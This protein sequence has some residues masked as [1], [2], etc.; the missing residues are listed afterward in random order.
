MT[1]ATS[2][3]GV[4]VNL[5]MGTASTNP[6]R[7]YEIQAIEDVIGS[8]FADVLI[9]DGA[10]NE[11]NGGG[12]NDFING[13][14]GSDD[15]DGQLGPRDFVSFTGAPAK[16]RASLQAGTASGW[17]SDS[18]SD[19]EEIGGSAFGDR[20]TGD[21]NA[22]ELNGA[23]GNDT[24]RG[25]GGADHIGADAGRDRVFPGPGTDVVSGDSGKDT[26]DLST[27]SRSV[28]INLLRRRASGDGVN[29]V[30]DFENA[31]GFR[32]AD[33]LVGNGGTNQLLGGRGDDIVG[34]QGGADRLVGGP[35]QDRLNGGDGPTV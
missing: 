27:A 31:V 29:Q 12:G 33:S 21:A 3:T 4:A 1:Y 6:G 22:N 15:L 13:R 10:G 19:F 32:F 30:F 5:N 26:L 34:G 25:L 20:L 2:A 7:D 17:G 23:G 18:I 14:G 28:A 9:G 35:G 8:S 11:I 24:L 16:I